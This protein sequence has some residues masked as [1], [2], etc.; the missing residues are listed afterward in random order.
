MKIAILVSVTTVVIG[1]VTRFAVYP[2]LL[3]SDLANLLCI[4]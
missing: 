4:V 2:M 1:S 3:K